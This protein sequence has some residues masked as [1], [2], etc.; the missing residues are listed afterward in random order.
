MADVLS[1]LGLS[2]E[3]K[4]FPIKPS[5]ERFAGLIKASQRP[6]VE[7]SPEME[8]MATEAILD[9]PV[10]NERIQGLR[11]D[12]GHRVVLCEDAAGGSPL[13]HDDPDF[14]IRIGRFRNDANAVEVSKV[15]V[16]V[17]VDT[18]LEGLIVARNCDRDLEWLR[19][20]GLADR[21]A[22]RRRGCDEN[23]H[24]GSDD[25]V[26][27]IHDYLLGVGRDRN[28]RPLNTTSTIAGARI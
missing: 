27:S 12:R 24:G 5:D 1:F 4:T 9:E 7:V 23:E 14:I 15:A 3:L 16:K 18:A 6:A 13:K 19:R 8:G 17:R 25:H 2:S 26:D 22:H 21:L 10:T 20:F 11:E 28:Y